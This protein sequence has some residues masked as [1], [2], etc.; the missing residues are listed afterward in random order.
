M[1]FTNS[2]AICVFLPC[3][4][5]FS[6]TAGKCVNRK[7]HIIIVLADDMGWNDVSFRANQIPTPNMDALAYNGVILNNHYAQQVC[8]PSRAALMT[9]KYPIRLGMQSRA[10]YG[11]EKR[12]LPL[13]ENIMPQY[14]KLFGYSTYL[15]GKW[16]LGFSQSEYTPLQRGFDCH[17]G[18]WTGAISYYDHIYEDP[19]YPQ[20]SGHS[21]RRNY[22]TAWDLVGK[23]ATDIFTDEAVDLI[24]NHPPSKPMFMFLSHLATHAGNEGK[25]LEAPQEEIDKFS[26]IHDPNR[27]TYA[28]MVSKLDQSIGK[29]VSALKQRRMLD[30]SVILFLSDNG[31]PNIGYFKNWGSNFPFRGEKATLWEGGVKVPAFIWSPLINS[32]SRVSTD[33]MHISDWLPTFVGLA[34]CTQL[35]ETTGHDGYNQW[36]TIS[37]GVPTPRKEVLIDI[38]EMN[39][40][41]AIRVNKY[42]Y[43]NG[44][45]RSENQDGYLN[46]GTIT[47]GHSPDYN[48]SRV[49]YSPAWQSIR[50]PTTVDR[51]LESH[52][53]RLRRSATVNC[54]NSPGPSP[55]RNSACLFDLEND[56]CEEQDLSSVYPAIVQYMQTRLDSY[57]AELVPQTEFILYPEADPDKFNYTWSIWSNGY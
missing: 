23:Y 36:N 26:Y 28:A 9:G 22:T 17:T 39:N 1:T 53:T 15:V 40:R 48:I 13:S 30:N 51:N 37:V 29:V 16:H 25:W 3:V 33:L 27:R 2:I 44:A 14:L 38:D 34:G 31:A 54:R 8:T 21:M 5:F 50:G 11:A 42:K 47:A 49:V 56:P 35:N 52:I 6:F 43:I 20:Y 10:L 18:Y 45:S 4:T 32:P 12:G 19:G 24:E 46:R 41:E 57:R 55:C 7:P